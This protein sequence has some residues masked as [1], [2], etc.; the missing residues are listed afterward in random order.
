[1]DSWRDFVGKLIP[2]L[3]R[4]IPIVSI[5][6]IASKRLFAVKASAPPSTCEGPNNT[7]FA[8]SQLLCA[9][10]RQRAKSPHGCHARPATA[11]SCR[12]RVEYLFGAST[13][14]LLRGLRVSSQTVRMGVLI[15]VARSR[16]RPWISRSLCGCIGAS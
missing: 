8:Q 12:S 5:S 4:D 7:D 6:M 16:T 2:E 1:M 13:Q 11:V 10:L 15:E 14:A 9:F 3:R